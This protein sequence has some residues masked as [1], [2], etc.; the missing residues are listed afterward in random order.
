MTTGSNDPASGKSEYGRPRCQHGSPPCSSGGVSL[1]RSY[2]PPRLS[3]S[4][5]RPPALKLVRRPLEA[6]P[7]SCTGFSLGSVCSPPS[8]DSSWTDAKDN[9]RNS[10]NK[11]PCG[12]VPRRGGA[13]AYR[14]HRLGGRL[15]RDARDSSHCSPP[16]GRTKGLPL[17][18]VAISLCHGSKTPWAW[19]LL[20][21]FARPGARLEPTTTAVH[22][23]RLFLQRPRRRRMFRR[24][25]PA[26]C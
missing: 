3:G 21:V 11:V 1:W 16:G 12:V 10:A 24:T 18:M 20:R 19:G 22:R 23:S 26:I 2:L 5:R 25:D 7:S 15:V 9:R 6:H 8:W 4:G 14:L 17:S 13:R